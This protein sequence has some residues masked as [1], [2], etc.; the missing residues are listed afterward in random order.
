MKI[1]DAIKDLWKNN[2]FN[3]HRSPYDVKSQLFNDY[4][5]TCS[6]ITMQLKSCKSFLRKETKGWIQKMKY[7][8]EYE[9]DSRK[10][11]DIE[12]L[13]D[14]ENLWRACKSSFESGEYWDACL[15]AFRHLE[16]K[17]REK[18]G[19]S[20]DEHGVDLVNKAFNPSQGI[21]KIPNCATRSEEEG[22]FFIN[23]G[24]VMFHRNAK[25]HREGEVER[26]DAIK[27][28]CY[29]DYLLNIVRTAHKNSL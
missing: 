5:I 8:H 1:N 25:G 23:R 13:L 3:L 11:S 18:A 9:N 2:F 27:I 10:S 7:S 14:N 29:V 26:K 15:H 20:P 21:L 24:I 28:I 4:G 6:N 12:R 22:F 17:I 19:L 16:T